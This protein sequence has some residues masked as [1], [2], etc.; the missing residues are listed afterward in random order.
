[1]DEARRRARAAAESRK[2]LNTGSG[3]RLGGTSVARGADMRRVIADAIQRR[4][5][6]TRGCASGTDESR[7]LAD[8]ATRNGFRTQA[9]EDDANERAIMQ[10][11][12]ELL[13]EEEKEKWG[14]DYMPPSQDHPGGMSETRMGQER[15]KRSSE[16]MTALDQDDGSEASCSRASRVKVHAR[17]TT[18]NTTDSREPD[19]NSK[20]YPLSPGL[21]GPT[22]SLTKDF[23]SPAPQDASSWEC[24]ICTLHNPLPHL[25]CSACGLERPLE[26]SR[27]HPAAADAD[28]SPLQP[29]APDKR[30]TTR[31]RP[32]NSGYSTPLLPQSNSV[33][34]PSHVPGW[35]QCK[36]CG[37]SMEQIWWT[38]DRCGI[39]KNKS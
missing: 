15:M 34:Q 16:A 18:S 13:Q 6:V 25:C 39:M 24:P 21:V 11:Y 20:A 36:N 31:V 28:H 26:I 32:P 19:P 8:Y 22:E 14:K 37:Q 27:R 35:W 1:M 5:T 30:L 17:S 38:C 9:E 2:L 33:S 23:G 3:Q 10:A 4:L 12:I 29:K 7:T